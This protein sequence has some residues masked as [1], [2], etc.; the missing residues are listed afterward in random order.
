[1][2]DKMKKLITIGAVLV[3]S[4][5]ARLDHVQ[6]NDIDQSQ[7]TLTPISV[8]TSEN[9][10]ELAAVA[11]IAAAVTKN[12]NA[13]QN[14]KALRDI[15]ALMNM[16]PRTG[17]PVFNETYAENVLSQLYSQCPSGNITG[18]KNVRE[19]RSYGPVS[20]EIIYLQ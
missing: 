7:G 20:G 8:K 6:I 1:M 11:G 18:I 2:D 10:V 4:A 5:C 9:A 15:L 13:Q 3:L 17:N 14:L 12:E 16:G 19:A